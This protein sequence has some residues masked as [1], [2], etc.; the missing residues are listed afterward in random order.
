MPEEIG[1]TLL[2]KPES[3]KELPITQYIVNKH[4]IKEWDFFLAKKL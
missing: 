2:K 4:S 3:P 1:L